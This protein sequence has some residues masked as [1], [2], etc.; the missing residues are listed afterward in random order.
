MEPN[1][2]A[3]R[4]VWKVLTNGI[5]ERIIIVYTGLLI[6]TYFFL[7]YQGYNLFKMTGDGFGWVILTALF[8]VVIIIGTFRKLIKSKIPVEIQIDSKNEI[9]TIIYS[10]NDKVETPFENLG[11]AEN[12]SLLTLYKTFVGTRG[13]DVFNKITEIIGLQ[14]TLSWKTVH[15][16]EISDE[17]TKQ[18]ILQTK[19]DNRDL[20][21]WER[22]IIST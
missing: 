21:L 5:I 1:Q 4:K 7:L 18:G 19:A 17:L 22:L 8:W 2:S 6:A 3:E 14:I 10:A 13:Q 16:R 20:N 15:I 11:F 9:C 12:G